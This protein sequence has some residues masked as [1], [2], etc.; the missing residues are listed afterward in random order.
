MLA[1]IE[2]AK[3]DKG[4]NPFFLSPIVRNYTIESVVIEKK[5]GC[6]SNRPMSVLL[7]SENCN[8]FSVGISLCN[9]VLDLLALES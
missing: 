7:L 3:M 2:K 9:P 1:P 4:E 5:D 8:N 6:L